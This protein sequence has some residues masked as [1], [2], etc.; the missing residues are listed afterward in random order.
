MKTLEGKDVDLSEYKGKVV[1]IVNTASKCGLT[2]QYKQLQELHS[3][4][5]AKGLK[6]L[7]FPCNQ[8]GGQEPGTAKQISEFCTKNYGVEFE[9]FSKVDV[10]GDKQAGLYKYLNNL[11]LKPAGKGKIKWNFE[12]FILDRNGNPI[13]RFGPRVKPD[14]EEVL[15]VINDALGSE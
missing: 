2:P 13:A 14:S 12:K 11:D 1:L 5:E 4:Y 10:N 3:K 8:F 7:G 6:I 15:K 9:M